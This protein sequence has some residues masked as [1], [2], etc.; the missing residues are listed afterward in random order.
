MERRSIHPTTG[1]RDFTSPFPSGDADPHLPFA[2]TLSR[3]AP[4]DLMSGRAA[5]LVLARFETLA[6]AMNLIGGRSNCGEGGE[7]QGAAACR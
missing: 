7:D 5:P 4:A 6:E 1:P 3:R 2:L